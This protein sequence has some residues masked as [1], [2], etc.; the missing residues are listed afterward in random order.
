MRQAFDLSLYLVIG[1]GHCAGR[2]MADV[3]SAAARGGADVVLHAERD[4]VGLRL[5]ARAAQ[6]QAFLVGGK[7]VASKPAGPGRWSAHVAG[8]S[9]GAFQVRFG[10]AIRLV[11]PAADD[12]M[13]GLTNRPD[14]AADIARLSG[15]QVHADGVPPAP[16][17]GR[18]AVYATFLAAAACVVWAA[19][20]RRVA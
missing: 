19:L 6:Q 11:R 4:G 1:P 7:T 15:G 18:S 3:A 9:S 17:R 12:E 2:D 16:G 14:I 20:K 10:A 5:S 8:V 13:G